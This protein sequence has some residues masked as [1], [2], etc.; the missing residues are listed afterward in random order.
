MGCKRNSFFSNKPTYVEKYKH[1][2]MII[3]ILLILSLTSLL[4]ILKKK[5][6]KY[7]GFDKSI[8]E[9]G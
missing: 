6:K 8:Q 7:N 3:L 5:N 1:F 2:I 4:F 9:Q